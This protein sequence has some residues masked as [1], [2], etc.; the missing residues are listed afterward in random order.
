MIAMR[1]DEAIQGAFPLPDC[2]AR[3]LMS[4]PASSNA[5]GPER[6]IAAPAVIKISSSG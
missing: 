6:A 4:V 3:T 2:H 5:R 1:Y